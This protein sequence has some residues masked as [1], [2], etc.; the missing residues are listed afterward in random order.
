MYIAIEH[1]PQ[2]AVYDTE[3]RV[4]DKMYM[5]GLFI[6]WFALVSLGVFACLSMIIW[7]VRGFKK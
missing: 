7:I 4:Y 1:N 5:S 2:M 6:S 3:T